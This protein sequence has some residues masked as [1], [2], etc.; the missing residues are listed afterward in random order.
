MHRA[1]LI[2][3]RERCAYRREILRR[4]TH[5]TIDCVK[6]RSPAIPRQRS[7]SA[8]REARQLNRGRLEERA[9]SGNQRADQNTDIQSAFESQMAHEAAD[10]A[11]LKM[12]RGAKQVA[13]AYDA[14]H[15]PDAAPQAGR[16]ARFG[17]CLA[18]FRLDKV[19][20]NRRGQVISGEERVSDL[21]MVRETI[22]DPA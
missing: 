21:P 12:R 4:Q 1:A 9:M 22:G 8:R 19:I 13:V 6:A 20:S 10:F 5:S 3:R 15:L 7:R 18:K 14:G 16:M 11:Q 17:G 2:K